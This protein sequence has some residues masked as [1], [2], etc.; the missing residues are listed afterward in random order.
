[1]TLSP[2]HDRMM[3][4][5]VC[6]ISCTF[7]HSGHVMLEVSTAHFSASSASHILFMPSLIF[8]ALWR[9]HPIF[10]RW[11]LRFNVV[12]YLPWVTMSGTTH[13]LRDGLWVLF[14]PKCLRMTNQGLALVW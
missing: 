6:C 13:C 5:L 12:S 11:K 8:P 9:D 4:G 7:E 14:I 10:Q 1:M 3:T 2:L